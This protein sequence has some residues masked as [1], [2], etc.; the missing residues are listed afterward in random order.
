MDCYFCIVSLPAESVADLCVIDA[1]DDADALRTVQQ[2]ALDWPVLASLSLYRGERPVAVLT[3]DLR[4][5]A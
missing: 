2:M 4:R 3:G 1:A 5:A